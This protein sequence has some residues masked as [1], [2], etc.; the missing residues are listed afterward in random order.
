MNIVEVINMLAEGKRYGVVLF[1][2]YYC[3]VLI[4]FLVLYSDCCLCIKE[5]FNY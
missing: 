4:K 3:I 2:L 5:S 1:A